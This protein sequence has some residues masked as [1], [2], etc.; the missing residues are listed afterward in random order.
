MVHCGFGTERLN[1][2]QLGCHHHQQLYFGDESRMRIPLGQVYYQLS[3]SSYPFFAR[4][5]RLNDALIPWIWLPVVAR[6]SAKTVWWKSAKRLL[7]LKLS[8]TVLSMVTSKPTYTLTACRH[9]Q[10]PSLLVQPDLM[11]KGHEGCRI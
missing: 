5:S 4:V 6:D 1:L 3:S 7:G 11:R 2:Q 8:K 10:S 9:T